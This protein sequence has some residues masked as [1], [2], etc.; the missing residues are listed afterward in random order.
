M[1]L[2]LTSP[3]ATTLLVRWAAFAV[4]DGSLLSRGS[5]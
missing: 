4:F 2:S 5:G 3:L 1:V